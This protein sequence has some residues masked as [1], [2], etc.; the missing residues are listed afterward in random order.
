[1]AKV[2]EAEGTVQKTVHLTES[3]N[4][5]LAVRLAGEGITFSEWVRG[6]V[7]AYLVKSRP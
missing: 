2:E 6:C 4:R 7:T 1:M 5:A 3:M